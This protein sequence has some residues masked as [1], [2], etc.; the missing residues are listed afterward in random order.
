LAEPFDPRSLVEEFRDEAREQVDSL[1]EGLLQLERDGGLDEER[2]GSLMRSLH[3]LK[4]NAGMLG[5]SAI[6]DFVHVLETVLKSGSAPSGVTVDRLFDGAS[7]LRQA[8]EAAGRAGEGQ[9]FRQLTASRLRL[10][11]RDQGEARDYGTADA[12]TLP[13]E[14]GDGSGDDRIRV[15]FAKLDALLNEVGEL[16][17]EADALAGAVEDAPRSV[18]REWAEAVSRRSDR[19]RDATMSLRLVPLARVFGRFH[20][21]VR[22]LAREQGKEAR[23][24]VSGESTEVDKST[25][26]ALAGP[27]LHL[28]RNAIDH[29]IAGPE[30]REAA[31][32][33]RH[34]TIMLTAEQEGDHVR[35]QVEDD[36]VGLDLDAIRARARQQDLV[37]GDAPITDEEAVD[38]IFRPGLSTRAAANQVSGRGVGLDVVYRGVRDLRGEL[39]VQSPPGGGTRFVMRLPLTVAIV[40]SLI[41][42]AAGETLAVPASAVAGAARLD[43]IERVGA[44]EVVRDGDRLV[45]LIDPDR[46]FGWPPTRRGGYGVLLHHGRGGAVVV[47]ERL[48][49]QRDLVV[50]A[51]PAYGVPTSGVSGASVMPG[52]RVILV[53]DPAAVIEMTGERKE[54]LDA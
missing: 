7:A 16:L 20:G 43:R 53:L 47:A 49:D 40:P 52:G 31:G 32:K 10:E 11:E 19:L 45:P 50:K 4:G 35:I 15:P 42:E 1:D 2:R 29:G 9:A 30:A 33:A 51:L 54:R 8:V 24:M 34:G 14:T 3:T 28:V 18:A 12:Q 37:D 17:A 21:L 38:L 13:D 39:S 26:D 25:A 6:R 46:L 27:L 36:G 48:V 44:T 5:Y 22:R 23:L 41:F